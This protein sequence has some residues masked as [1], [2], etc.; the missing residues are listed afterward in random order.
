MAKV[1]SNISENWVSGLGGMPAPRFSPAALAAVAT[2]HAAAWLGLMA[3]AALPQ[4]PVEQPILISLVT[5]AAAPPKVARPAEPPK[6]IKPVAQPAA[7][8]PSEAPAPKPLPQPEPVMSVPQAARQDAPPMPRAEAVAQPVA[9]EQ[10]PQ[11]DPAPPAEVPQVVATVSEPAPIEP[12]RFNANYL[13]NPAPAYPR[14]SRRM[15]EEGRVLLRVQVS[16]AGT[17]AQ[18]ELQ[19]SSG[20]PR[21][22]EVAAETVR[23]WKFAPARQGGRPVE[24]WVIVPILFSLKS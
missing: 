15:G 23:L 8:K 6:A 18:V 11:A 1:G 7:R 3:T 21:L 12:P 10:A 17:P 24:A 16:T 19:Q 4:P 14:L 5:P 20:F 22:D 2:A 13:N 9:A